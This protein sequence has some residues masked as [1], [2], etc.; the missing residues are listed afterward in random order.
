M[1]KIAYILSVILAAAACSKTERELPENSSDFQETVDN[2]IKFSA[3]FEDA[4][5]AKS[6]IS[7]TSVLWEA[8]DEISI[9]WD[10][11]STTAHADLAGAKANFI[12]TVGQAAEYFA[13]YPSTAKVSLSEGSLTV[14]IP[15]E[16]N[17]KFEDANI[18]IARTTERNL[19]FKNLCAL[20][21]F[22]LERDDIAKVVLYG[23]SGQNL[24]GNVTLSLD[25]NGVPSVES[26]DSPD[27][28]IVLTPASGDA[29]AAGI[30]YFSA[31]PITLE[32]GV[33]FTLTT[34]SGNTIFGKASRNSADLIR[35]EVLNFG[36]LDN[37]S[38]ADAIR[39]RFIFGPERGA[40]AT[41][42]PNNEWPTKGDND[43]VNLS[44]GTTYP[45]I[46]DNNEY[47]FFAQDI[48]GEAKFAWRT[49]NA[50]ADCIAIQTDKGYFGMPAI[51]GLKL[52]NV[53]VGKCRRGKSDN[54]DEYPNTATTVGITDCIPNATESLKR[55][56]PG[57]NLQ[58]W[59]SWNN[60][61][62]GARR[63]VDHKFAL[64]GTEENTMYFLNSNTPDIGLYFAHLILT[65]EKTDCDYKGFREDSQ[66]DSNYSIAYDKLEGNASEFIKAFTA[67]TGHTPRSY[68]E[69]S[70]QNAK[71]IL[72]GNTSRQ[73]TKEALNG[74]THG[75]KIAFQGDKLVIAGTDDNWIAVA[76]YEFEK[77]V[78]KS[79]QYMSNGRLK[80]PDDLS[81]SES[82]DD[83]QMIARLLSH[84]HTQFTFA[85]EKVMSCAG[86][87]Q[88][89]IAQGATSDG[90]HVYFVLRNSGD[91]LAMVFKYDMTGKQV[92]KSEIFNGGHCNDM[93]LNT[94]TSKLYVAHGSAAPKKLTQIAANDLSIGTV[95]NISVG[96]GAISYNA[97]R[98]CYAI[99]QGGKNLVLCDD[100]FNKV[101][102]YTRT[103]NT[104]YT[105]QGM[106][107]D[108]S[109]VYFPMSS[110][111]DNILVAY[112][113]NGSFVTSLKVNLALESESMFYAAG[114][115]YVN[116]HEKNKGAQLYKI[117]PMLNYNFN[118]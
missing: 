88:V 25:E 86:E 21:K 15:A 39:I 79:S 42:D 87:G 4:P 103:D 9:L 89:K 90:T 80:L 52:T 97:A 17:G 19:V 117:T 110:S 32:D 53:V 51:E 2:T 18:A 100:G 33:S 55:Y 45:Y 102:S 112:D 104:G 30:Y 62:G 98:N 24:V 13:V 56:I 59:P 72:V 50:Y 65:Y 41:L 113:W 43:K 109:Y 12:A 94:R 46:V 114:N 105:A 107:S 67:Y 91:S 75:F 48:S 60:D 44:N 22:S 57:G 5:V 40:K 29:F 49:D 28:S 68:L 7:G 64:S 71:E 99:S 106:G 96:T 3:V 16:Q 69:T 92:A 95:A 118:Y 36:R 93:T 14:G 20:G 10:G 26:T 84:G 37:I 81:I 58:E 34:V 6:E 116:F 47:R 70:E 63:V 74:I 85:T 83:P 66:E 111:K 27:D 73:E 115:Y 77:T 108:D 61:D 38:N 11:G 76:L 78:L 31:I 54:P 101:Q 82:Y 8:G 1:K 35:S 23:N